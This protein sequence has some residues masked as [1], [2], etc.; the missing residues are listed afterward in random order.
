MT[1]KEIRYQWHHRHR[2]APRHQIPR[3]ISGRLHAPT[4]NTL[5]NYVLHICGEFKGLDAGKE[6]YIINDKVWKEIGALTAKANAT[7]P[8]AFGRSI[9]DIAE[10]RT[11]FT[12]EA[13]LVWSTLYAPIL[14]R[15][16]FPNRRYYRHYVLLISIVTRCMD[17][18]STKVSRDQLRKDIVQWYSEYEK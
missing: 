3:L 7:I 16:R 17:F 1:I 13:Y 12:A 6:D 15:D 5:H 2:Q 10:D 4:R 8:A 18:T 14:L 9:P 11:Y